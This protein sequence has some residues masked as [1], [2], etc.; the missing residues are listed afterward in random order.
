MSEY[1][2]SPRIGAEGGRRPL[3]CTDAVKESVNA[4]N[5]PPTW[6]LRRIDAIVFHLYWPA[7]PDGVALCGIRATKNPNGPV[8]SP[9]L[10]G[11]CAWKVEIATGQELVE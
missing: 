9:F 7:V 1:T 2:E 10:C 6:G 8:D 4:M 11:D 5:P 3:E